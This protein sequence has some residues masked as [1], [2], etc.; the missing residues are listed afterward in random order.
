MKS[1]ICLL[2]ISLTILAFSSTPL[3][4]QETEKYLLALK[5]LE[6][7]DTT[8]AEK[9]LT[10]SIYDFND[11]ASCRLLVK[12]C[13]DQ[14]SV[15]ARNR[16]LKILDYEIA[17]DLKNLHFRVLHAK[18]LEKAFPYNAIGEYE[19][20]IS[21]DST[22]YEALLN[23][24]LL[25]EESVNMYLNAGVNSDRGTRI[26]TE[27]HA[28]GDYRLAETCFKKCME[29]NPDDE[30][31]ALHLSYLYETARQTAKA[32]EVLAGFV[33][34]NPFKDAYVYL[35]H[36]Y[37]K[38]GNNKLA[39]EAF[40][41]SLE[42]MSPEEKEDFTFNSVKMILSYSLDN[43]LK[44]LSD[45]EL[46]KFV[47][48]YWDIRDPLRLTDYNERQLEHFS[49]V[50]YANVR[51]K[52]PDSNLPG[53]KTDRGEAVIRYGEPLSIISLRPRWAPPIDDNS[54]ETFESKDAYANS[55][56]TQAEAINVFLKLRIGIEKEKKRQRVSSGQNFGSGIRPLG[57]RIDLPTE[58]FNY[59][60]M[61]LAFV[62]Q[63]FKG[64]YKFNR[65][66][67]G[68]D[69]YYSQ[70]P[71]TTEVLMTLYRKYRP[72]SYS[73]RF[74]GP[75]LS[76]PFNL[77]QFKNKNP[78]ENYTDTYLAFGVETGENMSRNS[79]QYGIFLYD[80]Y[81][82]PVLEKRDSIEILPGSRI[83]RSAEN[84]KF[85]V[86]SYRMITP[87]DS[88]YLFFEVIRNSDKG[89]YTSHDKVN[90]RRFYNDSLQTSDL[91]LA[92]Y[93][94]ETA[95]KKGFLSRG[96]I[97]MIP[98]PMHEFSKEQDLYVYYEVYNLTLNPKGDSEFEQTLTLSDVSYQNK[99]SFTKFFNSIGEFLGLVS[100]EKKLSLVSNYNLKGKDH[101]LYLQIDMNRFAP[102]NYKISAMV[103]D[104]LSGKET[105]SE[106]IL[107]WQ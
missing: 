101:Q 80:R 6:K 24:G 28:Q 107:R 31:P 51:L 71:D 19:D 13:L 30:Q 54:L 48:A 33:S 90:I 14:E 11:I 12:L 89:V 22:C 60:D 83:I 4:P 5:A 41:K 42:L 44:N 105:I 98:N 43:K 96:S 85:A 34:L 93:L 73:P 45:V 2:V 82:N 53:W 16:T 58:V 21:K 86:N 32:S 106:T 59:E 95:H 91:V 66:A 39:Y 78:E 69:L 100:G 55:S 87:A 61:R 38:S 64:N 56:R 77:L 27:V 20:I 99:S 63:S 18:V 68:F 94:S 3:Y 50:A 70:M 26:R 57:G 62:D 65:K 9:L 88:D 72:E 76:A 47:N 23:L 52:N 35:G 67:K 10:E 84:K 7:N 1:F 81:F 102:G 49:R 74:E 92:N 97:N 17:R 40:R 37:C 36:L 25:A 104:K 75:A 15:S 79:Y 29:I 8:R 46:R 103:K